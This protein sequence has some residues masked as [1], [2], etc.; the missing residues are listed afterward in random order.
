[1]KN[2]EYGKTITD[3]DECIIKKPKERIRNEYN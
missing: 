3:K 2:I 1:M